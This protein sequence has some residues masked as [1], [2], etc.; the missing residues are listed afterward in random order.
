[1]ISLIAVLFLVVIPILGTGPLGARFLFGILIPYAAIATFIAG[2]IYRILLWA[3]SPVPFRITTTCG[4]QKSLPWVRANNLESPHNTLG[5]IG[6]MA[7]EV[8]LFRSLFRNT[9]AEVKE[10]PKIVYGSDKWLWLGGLAFHWSFLIIFLRHF[11]YFAEPIPAWVNTLQGLDGFFQ[12]SLPVILATDL[13]VVVALFFLLFRRIADRRLRYITLPADYFALFLLL[14]IALSGI[15]MRYLGK[16]DIVK[17]KELGVGILS[18]HPVMPDGIGTVFFVHFFL[19]SALMAYFPFSK[20][21]HMGGIFMSPTRNMTNDNRSRRHQNP[22]NYPVK[23]HT[24][25]EYEEEFRDKMK[26][27]G[28]P[29][30]KD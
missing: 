7:L 8:L 14:G 2:F 13:I 25:E 1:M 27:A 11:K 28:M 6:R 26:D 3:H 19:V 15:Y 16:T 21:M 10:G 20:L 22:W 29:I 30:E 4:Q 12:V 5:V 23:V 18:F 9:K 17:V 24:Y